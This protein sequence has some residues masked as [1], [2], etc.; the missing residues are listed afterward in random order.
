[1]LEKRGGGGK[2]KGGDTE[3][4]GGK[5]QRLRKL[6]EILRSASSQHQR[7]EV[8]ACAGRRGVERGRVKGGGGDAGCALAPLAPLSV[9]LGGG[10]KMERR[11]EKMS[12]MG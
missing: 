8:Q 6:L 9:S 4:K 10:T 7:E 12:V 2:G 3:R 1:M 5:E 11:R